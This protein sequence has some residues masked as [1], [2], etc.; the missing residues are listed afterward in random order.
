[1]TCPM[2]W[3]IIAVIFIAG[4]AGGF[5]NFLTTA[6][7]DPGEKELS[8]E[9]H[10][11]VGIVA[12]FVVP[13]FLN[14]SSSSLLTS[15]QTGKPDDPFRSLLVLAGFCLIAATSSRAFLSTVS[16]R[17]L[18][19][20]KEANKNADDAKKQSDDAKKQSDDAKK[21]AGDA[22]KEAERST[23]VAARSVDQSEDA[24]RAAI[25]ATEVAD[26]AKEAVE[27][28]L[29]EDSRNA[30]EEVG[31][32]D[33]QSASS[34]ELPV[35]EVSDRDRHV[36][37][38]LISSPQFTWRSASGVAGRVQMSLKEVEDILDGLVSVGLARQMVAGTGTPRRWTITALGRH[39]LSK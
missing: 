5:V 10:I 35:P 36:L 12:A 25:H 14:I 27:P 15:V 8:R 31:Q 23:D 3:Q 7:K 30:S 20:A 16:E 2:S 33:L 13:L 26:M 34:I 4:A 9:G 18:R 19:L 11:V 24:K 22:K 37:E 39:L 1:M 28:L 32:A 38:A 6:P 29:E 17:V 21:Q